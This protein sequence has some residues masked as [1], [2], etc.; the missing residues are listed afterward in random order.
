[1]QH[2][3]ILW[4]RKILRWWG[5][6]GSLGKCFAKIPA[7]PCTSSRFHVEMGGGGMPRDALNIKMLG[8]WPPAPAADGRPGCSK[9][10]L[11]KIKVS[12]IMVA[13]RH[14][15]FGILGIL[16]ALLRQD[17]GLSTACQIVTNIDIIR[18]AKSS[19]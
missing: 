13:C 15:A 12:L 4:R 7:D 14:S 9:S 18:A 19:S 17:R 11:F 8:R 10:Q 6:W 2:Q 16:E 1:M 5:S 3:A